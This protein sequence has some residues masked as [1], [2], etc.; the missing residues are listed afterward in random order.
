MFDGHSG[1]LDHKPNNFFRV[2]PWRSLDKDHVR[3]PYVFIYIFDWFHLVVH[4]T[5]WAC[6]SDGFCKINFINQ[7]LLS[8]TKSTWKAKSTI[9][10]QDPPQICPKCPQCSPSFWLTAIFA[11]EKH[12]MPPP[13]C[14]SGR[15]QKSPERMKEQHLKVSKSSLLKI[16]T[17]FIFTSYK[18]LWQ[19]PLP[20][21]HLESTW[22]N[23]HG[24]Q[25]NKGPT[26]NSGD[27]IRIA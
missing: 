11:K 22:C 23:S 27:K 13:L 20:L 4:L 10:W 26:T 3:L 19:E 8:S 7:P 15:L 2:S 18:L 21:H 1:H 17:V 24:L 12:G 6:C 5:I 16:N 25:F 14:S 9:H